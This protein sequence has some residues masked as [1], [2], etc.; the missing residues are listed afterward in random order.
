VKRHHLMLVLLCTACCVSACGSSSQATLTPPTQAET[1]GA[2]SVSGKVV[3]ARWAGLG[4]GAGGRLAVLKVQE[5]QRVEAG[6]E[7]AGLET[8]E[9]E[10]AVRAAQQALAGQQARL[11]QARATPAAA[12]VAAARAQL[13]AAQAALHALETAPQAR[14]LEEARLQV[15]VAKNTLY[16]TQLQGDVPGVPVNAQRAARAQAAAA[17]QS[18][19]IAELQYERVKAGATSEAL[20]A[21]RATVSQAE[22]ALERLQRGASREEIAALQ[23][24]VDAAQVG[25]EQAQWQLGQARLAAPFAGNVTLVTARVGEF[26]APGALVLTLADLGTLRIETTDL[27]Q[28]DL[29]RV[30]VGQVADLTFDALP[31]EV[32]QGRVTRIADM[33]TAGQGGTNFTLVVELHKPDVRLRW[34]MSAF[35]DIRVE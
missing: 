23:A 28:T 14:D 10:L 33:A 11:A 32:L 15:E 31:N 18:L 2:V 4:L 8:D 17:E 22:A 5:G 19:H 35:V 3:P 21:A 7:L 25:V 29:A 24:A 20:A 26:V 13:E 6:Q 1:G 27:D 30:R 34:G 12:D 9:L 16:A